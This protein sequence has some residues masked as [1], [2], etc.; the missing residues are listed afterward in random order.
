MIRENNYKHQLQK[1]YDARVKFCQFNVGDYVFRNNGAS[2]VEATGKLTPT[3]E[4]PYK[5][6]RVLAKG[7]YTLEK[8]DGASI[9]RT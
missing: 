5:V 9:P 3:W 8:L 7:A 2:N 4:G 6:S 1:Y